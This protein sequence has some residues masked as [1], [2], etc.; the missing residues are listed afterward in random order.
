MTKKFKEIIKDIKEVIAVVPEPIHFK[1]RKH[2]KKKKKLDEGKI[3]P[4][5]PFYGGRQVDNDGWRNENRKDVYS[6]SK[7]IR[8]GIKFTPE[9]QK[10]ISAYTFDSFDLNNSLLHAHKNKISET[11][12]KHPANSDAGP[13]DTIKH[14]DHAIKS[15]PLKHDLYAYS[16]VSWDPREKVA[17]KKNKIINSPAYISATHSRNVADSFASDKVSRK[18]G[19]KKHIIKF[20]LKRGDHALPVEGHT[21]HEG[22]HEIIIGRG[23]KLKYLGTE[24]YKGIEHPDFH[25]TGYEDD[26]KTI[27]IHH[28]ELT[29]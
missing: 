21:Q 11:H 7:K 15:N 26:A 18:N 1:G 20:H 29:K 9:Q 27:H 13:G 25:E 5:H 2:P 8:K 12:P 22:E 3:T 24:S 17:G 16:A 4:E 14:L 28:V 19:Y 6:T 10:H 23:S